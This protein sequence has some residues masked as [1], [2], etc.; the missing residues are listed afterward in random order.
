M[1]KKTE[2]RKELRFKAV[3]DG[4]RLTETAYCQCVTNCLRVVAVKMILI[5]CVLNK[6]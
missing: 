1:L 2:I 6:A 5:T 3:L 4:S